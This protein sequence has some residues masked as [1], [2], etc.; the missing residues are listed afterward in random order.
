[1]PARDNSYETFGRGRGRTHGG[2]DDWVFDDF[3]WGNKAGGAEAARAGLA[4]QANQVDQR[5]GPVINREQSAIDYQNEQ[6]ARF[7]QGRLLGQLG[8]VARGGTTPA[9]QQL[10]QQTLAAAYAQR[11]AAASGHGFGAMA[12][13]DRNGM[14]AA[15]NVNLAGQQQMGIQRAND[16]SAARDQFSQLAD[17]MRQQDLQSRGLRQEGAWNQAQLTD[18]QRAANDAMARFYLGERFKVGSDQLGANMNFER[19]SGDWQA[20]QSSLSW[21]AQQHRDEMNQRGQAAAMKMTGDALTVGGSIAD[22]DKDKN[23]P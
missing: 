18:Q 21:Q 13:A 1:M 2:Y 20:Q 17:A 14:L 8:G 11:S 23:K 3:E 4:N 10:A 9:Q 5:T 7:D 6:D 12:G 22:E 15:Q 16:M 19:Q